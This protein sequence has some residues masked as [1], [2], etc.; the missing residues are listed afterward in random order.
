MRNGTSLLLIC[1]CATIAFGREEATRDF[2]KTVALPAGRS[3]HIEHSLGSVNIHTHAR[4]EVELRA[5]IQCSARAIAEARDCVNQIKITV[6]E[7]NAG[8]RVHTEY[9]QTSFFNGR[10]GLS[11]GVNYDIT[12]PDTAPLEVRNQYGEV[13]VADLHAAA[14][15][16]NTNG[17]VGFRNGRGA[18]RIENSYAEVQVQNNDG[19]VTVVSTNGS[20]G[21]SDITGAVDIRNRYA[22]VRAANIGKRLDLNCGNCSVTVSNVGG[23]ANITN[24]FGPV[25]VRDAKADLVVQNQNGRV[26]A[27]GV[28][29]TADLRTS[30]DSVRFSRIGKGLT[31]RASNSS[32]GGDTVGES[33]VVETSY[34]SIDL[35]GV[36]GGA[37]ATANN[38]SIRLSEIGGE[39]YARTSYAGVEVEESAGPVT[40]ENGNGSVTVRMKAGQR[41]QPISLSTSYSPIRVTV[42][43][44]AGYN[45]TAR[46]SYGH[47][48]SQ[49]EMAV[50]G[51][52]GG[53]SLSGRIAGGGCELRLIDQN[54]NIDILN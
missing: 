44:G 23:A 8:V 28:S 15:I 30:Y 16:H 45:V 51:Q 7:T 13:N 1:S 19:D 48:T 4:A 43:R 38:T 35:R 50:S 46:T 18:Q 32:V 31:V 14:A 24:T 9:P 25:T 26:E 54:G 3:L 2:S 11:Y 36:K 53:D 49:P 29:G 40:V 27:T 47:I 22:E 6:E 37:R 12:M 33:A 41:C 42:P 39:I 34:A 5:S 20:V 10:R 21:T 17:R 52:I